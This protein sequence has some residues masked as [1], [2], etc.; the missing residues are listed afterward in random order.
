MTNVKVRASGSW[1]DCSS[2]VGAH[3]GSSGGGSLAGLSRIPWEGGPDYYTVAQTGSQ[4]AKAAAAGWDEPTHFPIGIWLAPNDADVAALLQGV[5]IN[6]YCGIS[7]TPTNINAVTGLGMFVLA[8]TDAGEWTQG[9]IGSNPLCVGWLSMDEP[10]LFSSYA[11]YTAHTAAVRAYADGRFLW[12][13]WSVGPLEIGFF[14]DRTDEGM[15]QVDV[16][17]I[18]QYAYTSPDIRDHFANPGGDGVTA[19]EWPGPSDNPDYGECS[20]AYGWLIDRMIAHNPDAPAWIFIETKMPYLGDAGRDIILY[21]EIKGAIMS[22]II[23]ECR[24]IVYFDHNGFYG[25]PGTTG[26][27]TYPTTDPNTGQA[28][29]PDADP[30]LINGE[31]GL[32]DALTEINSLV[33]ELAPV[34]N[35]QSYAWDFGVAGVDTMLKEKDGYAYVF[36]GIGLG[37][38]TG[39]KTLTLP[40]G[41]T[42]DSVEVIDGVGSPGPIS[43]SGGDFSL[44]FTNEYDYFVGKVLV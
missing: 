30:A 7:H 5:G 6:T 16:N 28:V 3:V 33:T 41:V 24:G 1:V 39:T 21:D 9:E 35:T 32:R 2:L 43:V 18:D 8:Q 10:D 42:G 34:I 13:N 22:S 26:G 40:S 36:A 25:S 19:P 4:M 20:A 12:T 15:A 37:G 31:Q 17:S 23:H 38:T 27:G 29:D 44:T 14:D 11:A